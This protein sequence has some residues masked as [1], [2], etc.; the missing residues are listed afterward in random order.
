[1]SP[2]QETPGASPAS[3]FGLLSEFVVLLLGGLLIVIAMSNRVALRVRPTALTMLGV[4]LLYLGVRAWTRLRPA[5][6]RAQTHVRAG[7]LVLVGLLVIAIPFLRVRYASLLLGIAGAVLVLR[8][9]VAGLLS[10]RQP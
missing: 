7:S 3:L 10:F 2:N 4:L 1:M 9:L 6:A 8:G 5:A